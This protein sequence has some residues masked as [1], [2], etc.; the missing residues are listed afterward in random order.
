MA[1]KKQVPFIMWF[2]DIRK[3]DI[4]QVGGKG[5]N[6]G[7]LTSAGIPVPNGFCITAQAY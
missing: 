3:E 7:E 6:L 5:A 1:K 4:P 2:K